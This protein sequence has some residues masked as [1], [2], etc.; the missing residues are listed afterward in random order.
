M[1]CGPKSI[2]NGQNLGSTAEISGVARTSGVWWNLWD[3][4]RTYG[5]W[6][7]PMECDWN[8]WSVAGT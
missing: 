1:E 7:E 6:L 3:V 4:A 2:V 8:L 5:V